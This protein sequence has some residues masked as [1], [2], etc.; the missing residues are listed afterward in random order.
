MGKFHVHVDFKFP[1]DQPKLFW[2][3]GGGGYV[4]AAIMINVDECGFI[5]FLKMSY[6]LLASSV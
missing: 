5:S 3:K 6:G 2:G 1:I 4:N